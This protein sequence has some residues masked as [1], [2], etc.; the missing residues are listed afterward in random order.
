MFVCLAAIGACSDCERLCPLLGNII[1][2]GGLHPDTGEDCL[3]RTLPLSFTLST[4]AYPFLCWNQLLNAKQF[5][6][7]TEPVSGAISHTSHYC[8]HSKHKLSVSRP[9]CLDSLIDNRLLEYSLLM[10]RSQPRWR[11]YTHANTSCKKSY[12]T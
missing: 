6:S 1:L 12:Q 10:A 8:C 5:S 9:A 4:D 3:L 11:K 2:Q 7:V